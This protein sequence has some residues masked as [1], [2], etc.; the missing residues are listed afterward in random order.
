MPTSSQ[1]FAVVAHALGSVNPEDGNAVDGF[2]ETVFPAYPEAVR[3]LVSDFVIS[4]TSV[5]S[6]EDLA[7][8]REAVSELYDEAALTS[9][10]IAGRVTA[11]SGRRSRR[12]LGPI[13]V[14]AEEAGTEASREE[15]DVAST[16]QLREQG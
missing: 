13:V 1:A 9:G 4:Q 8:L 7:A 12:R 16:Q 15:P 10:P 6:T 5:P 2:Y 11:R 14:E 3:E